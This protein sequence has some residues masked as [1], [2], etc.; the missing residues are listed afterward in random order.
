MKR[1]I[2]IACVLLLLTGCSQV[3]AELDR[4][5]TLRAKLL[6]AQGVSFDARITADYGDKTYTFAMACRGDA[7]GNLTFSVVEPESISGIT[8]KL[9]SDGGVLT[10]D[11]TA[12]EFGLLAEEQLSPV[13]APWILLNA[14]RSGNITSACREEAGIRLSVSDGY[15][16]DALILDIWLDKGNLPVRGDVLQ[17]GRRILSLDVRN[18]VIM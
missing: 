4:A 5:M 2:A 8:G 12:L 10:F 1:L 17:E 11:R 16:E 7:Q 9:S 13:S 6:A 14:L 15:E 3:K 18:F